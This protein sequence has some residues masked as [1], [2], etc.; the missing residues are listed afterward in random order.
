MF[1]FPP[2][3]SSWTQTTGAA[4][5]SEEL[6]WNHSHL[7]GKTQWSHCFSPW[8]SPPAAG[9]PDF[10][11]KVNTCC[12]CSS[13]FSWALSSSPSSLWGSPTVVSWR[14]FKAVVWMFLPY[15]VCS[16]RMI[17]HWTF[18]HRSKFRGQVQGLAWT[19]VKKSQGRILNFQKAGELLLKGT[20]K[21][22]RRSDS[23]LLHTTAQTS[24]SIINIHPHQF[25]LLRALIL[26]HFTGNEY[27]QTYAV[28]SGP[29]LRPHLPLFLS[30]V[31]DAQ[32][33]RVWSIGDQSSSEWKLGEGGGADVAEGGVQG[34]GSRGGGI[35]C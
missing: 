29:Y 34:N 26:T 20:F 17:P 28:T 1:M 12:E 16:V 10:H 22:T 9:P 4:L 32:K 3:V 27:V 33:V 25:S 5:G 7:W 2:F 35:S 30:Q 18:T 13:S 6:L 21:I 24:E 11:Q 31:M 19:H 23:R 8:S 14:A 15:V